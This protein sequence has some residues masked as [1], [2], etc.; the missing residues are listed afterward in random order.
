MKIVENPKDVINKVVG[1]AFPSDVPKRRR[2]L[3]KKLRK[4][5]PKFRIQ[6]HERKRLLDL[7]DD[8]EDLISGKGA[9]EVL[10]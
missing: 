10:P 4:F 5:D 7:Y 9:P 2:A 6:P 3:I 1:V 8:L